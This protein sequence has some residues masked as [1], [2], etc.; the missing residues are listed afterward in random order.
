M[1]APV[2]ASSIQACADQLR[3]KGFVVTEMEVKSATLFEFEAIRNNRK[4]DITTDIS[5]KILHE[6]LDD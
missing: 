4:W 6:K 3:T 5:C 2:Q 1:T